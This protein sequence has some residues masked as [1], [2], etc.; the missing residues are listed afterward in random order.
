VT[1][2]LNFDKVMA[3]QILTYDLGGGGT[4]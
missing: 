2:K 3:K 4:K 1:Q